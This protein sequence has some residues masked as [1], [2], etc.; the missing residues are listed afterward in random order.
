MTNLD[1][2]KEY[3]FTANVQYINVPL[4]YR[5]AYGCYDPDGLEY[6]YDIFDLIYNPS[7][8]DKMINL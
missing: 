1:F 2:N 4:L 6:F 5:L 8:I 7:I 3:E